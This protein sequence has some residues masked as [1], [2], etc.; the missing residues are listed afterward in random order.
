MELDEFY[1]MDTSTGQFDAPLVASNRQIIAA[2]FNKTC[3]DSPTNAFQLSHWFCKW[4]STSSRHS[5]TLF[6]HQTTPKPKKFSKS[7]NRALEKGIKFCKKCR[8][9]PINAFEL[10]DWLCKWNSMSSSQ[11]SCLKVNCTLLLTRKREIL[12]RNSSF[13]IQ[14]F[15]KCFSPLPLILQMKAGELY[16]IDAIKPFHS[17]FNATFRLLHFFRSSI[18]LS[19]RDQSWKWYPNDRTH[20]V[21]S[22]KHLSSWIW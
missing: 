6:L 4:N 14:P 21:L 20:P 10:S 19:I 3:R 11:C 18:R 17:S 9:W 2:F 1:P 22:N 5:T 16:P 12:D 13:S 8:D 15:A 7:H